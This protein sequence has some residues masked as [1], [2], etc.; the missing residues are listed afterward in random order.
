MMIEP[1]KEKQLKKQPLIHRQQGFTLLEV[2]VVTIII[3]ILA[4]IAT[5]SWFSFLQRQRLNTATNEVF[6]GL[7]E[8]RTRAKREQTTWQFTAQQDGDEFRWRVDQ[9]NNFSDFNEVC[10]QDTGWQT[11]DSRIDIDTDLTSFFTP[12]DSDNCWQVRFNEKG[13][14]SS[15]LGQ[16][17]LKTENLDAR[18]CIIVST[19]LGAMRENKDDKCE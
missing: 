3:G 10:N 7:R 2:L 8:A 18:K 12:K 1:V 16:I 4:A 6:Q 19:V 13:R 17:T 11:V 5:P 9:S 15:P 14:V